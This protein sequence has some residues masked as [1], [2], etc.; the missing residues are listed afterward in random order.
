M[1]IKI[2]AVGIL[3]ILVFFSIHG[4]VH[5]FDNVNTHRSIVER[6]LVMDSYLD[7]HLRH[8]FGF[9]YGIGT[10]IDPQD[11]PIEDDSN[12]RVR[13]IAEWLEYGSYMEDKPI[14]R[15]NR[16]F[17]NPLKEWPDAYVD[18]LPASLSDLVD[19]RYGCWLE[20]FSNVTWA[21]GYVRPSLLG[22][23]AWTWNDHNWMAARDSFFLALTAGQTAEREK[24]WFRTFR[25]L[26]QVAHLLQD[27]GVPAHTRNDLLAH[28]E[29]IGGDGGFK[30]LYNRFEHYVEEKDSDIAQ[31]STISPVDIADYNLTR[32][33]D[34]NQYVGTDILLSRDQE[35]GLAEYSNANFFS[36]NSIFT[37][38]TDPTDPYHFPFPNKSVTTAERVEVMAEDAHFDLVWYVRYM[39]DC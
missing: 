35:A 10:L 20:D 6:A 23:T 29:L 39:P 16:H 8:A 1:R 13:T 12:V 24:Y 27:M 34:H 26:G 17:L 25:D 9:T 5:G 22:S 18:D 32:F 2:L 28:V 31:I 21:T 33:W 38:A 3:S 36:D 14:C 15:A 7:S 37:E 4:T 11:E 30:Y 19:V